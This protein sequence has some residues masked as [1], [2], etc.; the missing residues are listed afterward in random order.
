MPD[1][2]HC[3]DEC[4]V[5]EEHDSEPMGHAGCRGAG[6]PCPVCNQGLERGVGKLFDVVDA[7]ATDTPV[8]VSDI[9]KLQ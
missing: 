4:W 3:N 8:D 5:C 7:T 2:E 6:M 9:P 1:C